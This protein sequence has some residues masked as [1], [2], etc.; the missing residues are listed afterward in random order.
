ML[1]FRFFP[2]EDAPEPQSGDQVLLFL[3]DDRVLSSRVVGFDAKI[4]FFEL[5]DGSVT[6]NDFESLAGEWDAH[7]SSWCL[8]KC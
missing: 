7:K 3:P 1:N 2:T 8:S 4:P 6:E 5:P